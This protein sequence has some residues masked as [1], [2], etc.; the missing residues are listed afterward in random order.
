MP[1][2]EF[3]IRERDW[4]FLPL[5]EN[6]RNGGGEGGGGQRAWME[7]AEAVAQLRSVLTAGTITVSLGCGR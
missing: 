5:P 7:D 4:P 6:S 3:I 1:T 2:W